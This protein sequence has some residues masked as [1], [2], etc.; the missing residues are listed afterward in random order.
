MKTIR[1]LQVSLQADSLRAS[2]I[3]RLRGFISRVFPHYSEI[4]N[5]TQNG[6][7][8]FVYPELQ[9][10]FHENKPLIIAHSSGYKILLEIFQK[11]GYIEINHKRIE[12]PE[13]SIQLRE[14]K[15]GVNGKYERY[16]FSTPWMALNQEN[17]VE[18]K[19]L[20]PVD[21]EQKLNRI[22]WGNLRTL[23]HA[24]DYWIED[25]ESM[26]VSGHFKL[27]PVKFKGRSF[28]AFTGEFTTN[29]Q[30]PELLGLGKQV[31]RG[32]GSVLRLKKKD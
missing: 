25:Q 1:I 8:R 26:K 32:Y 28:A 22:L 20:D 19:N 4:H 18:Y 16:R 10:K 9:F 15:L 12:I 29:F 23:A 6:G 14:E 17:F 11:V 27:K 31:A 13:K 2:D 5:H 7:F 3:P 30:I 21:K 24:F